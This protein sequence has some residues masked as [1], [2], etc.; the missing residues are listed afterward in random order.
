MQKFSHLVTER[1]ALFVFC[2]PEGNDIVDYFEKQHQWD[3][4]ASLEQIDPLKGFERLVFG[5]DKL[6]TLEQQRG[7]EDQVD[8][9]EEDFVQHVVHD[10]HPLTLPSLLLLQVEGDFCVVPSVDDYCVHHLSVVDEASAGHKVHPWWTAKAH[11][12]WKNA[13]W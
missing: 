7:D 10:R 4:D 11:M 8:E 6:E 12:I 13:I 1:A 9:G 3:G 5:G 2:D